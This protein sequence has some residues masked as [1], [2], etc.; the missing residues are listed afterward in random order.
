MTIL[1]PFH[2]HNNKHA[3][4]TLAA[5][6]PDTQTH[7]PTPTHRW[8]E[9]QASIAIGCRIPGPGLLPSPCTLFGSLHSNL[10]AVTTVIRPDISLQI[11]LHG[12]S[13]H[14]QDRQ[15][16]PPPRGFHQ[17]LQCLSHGHLYLPS[18]RF[19]SDV[20]RPGMWH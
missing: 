19:T 4:N 3:N 16:T 1:L 7:P 14:K 13:P 20:R 17:P 9:A 5:S 15:S 2:L 8:G 12:R 6:H 10:S 11:V 18:N